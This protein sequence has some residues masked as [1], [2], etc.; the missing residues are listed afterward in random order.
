[1][2]PSHPA[3]LAPTS[4]DAGD[5]ARAHGLLPD[6][7]SLPMTLG[8]V[9]TGAL[10][11]ILLTLASPSPL[12]GFWLRLGPL[13]LLVLVIALLSATLLCLLRRPLGYV[14]GRVAVVLSL[15]VIVGAALSVAYSA[16][17]LLPWAESGGLLPA[18]GTEGLM[19]RVGLISAIVGA[20]LLRYLYLHRQW[21][22]QVEAVANARFQ[23]LQARIRPHFLFNSMNTIASLTQTNPRLAEEVTEDLADLFRASLS[24]EAT[25]TSL[26][27]ELELTRR[28]LN[29]E[30]QRLGD[31][32]RVDWDLVDLPGD[33]LVPPLILQPLVENAVYHGIQPSSEPG[34]IEIVGRYRRGMVTLIIR[35][36]LP[37]PRLPTGT[38][39]KG[40]RMAL[41]NVAQRMQ[42]MFPEVARV[43]RS[44]VDGDYLVRL[45]FPHPRRQ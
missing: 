39:H 13:S 29:I 15:T 23:T 41:D 32:M 42:A 35:N 10:L 2:S 20:L 6:F 36:T 28:Y 40:N 31:R 4:A 26:D 18:D 25:S 24:T 12:A 43:T 8:V 33:A 3:P 37:D 11:A 14:D 21:R 45:T 27:D 34:R 19:I 5:R 17:R 16:V 30:A 1:M 22:A 7:C 44:R 38:P 9:L